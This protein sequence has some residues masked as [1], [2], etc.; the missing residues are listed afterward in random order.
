MA[1][2]STLYCTIICKINITL[3]YTH[4]FVVALICL[5][6]SWKGVLIVESKTRAVGR[7]SLLYSLQNSCKSLSTS[8]WR[9]KKSTNRCL[10]CPSKQCKALTLRIHGRYLIKML[11]RDLDLSLNTIYLF[12][13]NNYYISYQLCRPVYIIL[14]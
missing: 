3:D 2:V 9:H 5:V 4:L 7:R 14:C 12:Q 6:Y 11:N 13:L 1:V 10:H 8:N